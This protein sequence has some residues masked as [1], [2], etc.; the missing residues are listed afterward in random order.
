MT[1]YEYIKNYVNV[2][3]SPSSIHGVGVFAMRD[4]EVGEDIFVNWEEESATVM[5]FDQL[6][7]RRFS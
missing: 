6:V 2:K 1:P 5:A 3:I 7:K 4:I